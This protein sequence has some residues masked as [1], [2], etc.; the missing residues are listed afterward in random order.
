MSPRGERPALIRGHRRLGQRRPRVV[1][2]P[3]VPRPSAHR[4]GDWASVHG[5][6]WLTRART[7][8]RGVVGRVSVA[9]VVARR[10]AASPSVGSV[11]AMTRFA[12]IRTSGVAT[13]AAPGSTTFP[14]AASASP[15][16]TR[17]LVVDARVCAGESLAGAGERE[18]DD[19]PEPARRGV[20]GVRV[21]WPSA[22]TASTRSRSRPVPERPA[23]APRRVASGGPGGRGRPRRARERP[24]TPRSPRGR[25]GPPPTAAGSGP[26][27]SAARSAGRARVDP[28]AGAVVEHRPDGV[29]VARQDRAEVVEGRCQR[30]PVG[31]A[32]RG[33]ISLPRRRRRGGRRPARR[34]RDAPGPARRWPRGARWRPSRPRRRWGPSRGTVRGPAAPRPTGRCRGAVPGARPERPH[35]RRRA[36]GPARGPGRARR[37]GVRCSARGGRP[38]IGGLHRPVGHHHRDDRRSRRSGNRGS[39]P[40]RA[41]AVSST[42]WT[43]VAAT[44][45]PSPEP[46]SEPTRAAHAAS[47]GSRHASSRDRVVGSVAAA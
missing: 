22:T 21:A 46:R 18:A 5:R 17:L 44:A 9:R 30:G 25:E 31:V 43:Q 13:R 40:S 39:A 33:S 35:G 10:C 15:A 14:A 19:L 32:R 47:Q 3:D 1:P 27:G 41:A 24:A 37:S 28:R 8:S 11:A 29:G 42:P 26:A 23:P 20:Q 2:E 38:A 36:R 12:A 4:C 7:S 45:R 16:R 6:A 34:R